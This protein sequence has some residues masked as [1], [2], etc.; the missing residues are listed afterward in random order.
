MIPKNE[1]VHRE[2]TSQLKLWIYGE[3][4]IGKTTFANQF[5][6]ALFINTDGNFRYIDSPVIPL[7]SN[8]DQD[9]WEMFISIVN[10]LASTK[11]DYKTIVVDLLED[12]FQYCR[13]YYMKKLKIDHEGDMGYGKGYDII[14]NAFLIVL[15][16]LINSG[17]NIIF[18]SHEKVITY[19]DRIGRE[20]TR[21]QPNVSDTITSKISGMVDITGRITIL[22]SEKEDGTVTDQRILY[23]TATKEQVGGNHI[24]NVTSEYIP[25]SYKELLNVYTNNENGGNK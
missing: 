18:I 20:L 21:F 10:E 7:V 16:T 12:V 2:S 3:P 4:A 5:P 1:K 17:Y 6:D 24:P 23:L 9:A 11:T 25:L 14:R 22:S 8:K 19:K 15:R 13:A